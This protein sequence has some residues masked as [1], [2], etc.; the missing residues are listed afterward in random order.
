MRITRDERSQGEE[1]KT[2]DAVRLI[3][4]TLLKPLDEDDADPAGKGRGSDRGNR[5][6]DRSGAG[7]D[8]GER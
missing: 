2:S 8:K 4:R 5:E 3:G 1:E 7:K 6:T